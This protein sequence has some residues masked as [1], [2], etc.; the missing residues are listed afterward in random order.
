MSRDRLLVAAAV[1][2]V[3]LCAATAGEAPRNIAFR[4]SVV[5]SSAADFTH[6]GHLVTDGLRSGAP[7][8]TT[9][10]RVEL[11][12]KSPDNEQAKCATDGRK[13]T[14][15]VVFASACWMKTARSWGYVTSWRTEMRITAI[16][17]LRRH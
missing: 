4:R 16:G 1:A 2:A 3:G 12:G 11:P 17:N 15:W 5:Q 6:V 8:L 10:T 13:D 14:K 7:L 9:E